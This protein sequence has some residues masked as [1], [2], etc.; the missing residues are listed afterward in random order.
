MRHSDLITISVKNGSSQQINHTEIQELDNKQ[1]LKIVIQ[2]PPDKAD[3]EPELCNNEQFDQ[4]RAAE[5]I[6]YPRTS[7]ARFCPNGQVLGM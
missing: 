4:L 5:T 2:N 3:D 1:S 7:G 6:P